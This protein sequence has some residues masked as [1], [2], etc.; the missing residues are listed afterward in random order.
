[1]GVAEITE[2]V[3]DEG[4]PQGGDQEAAEDIRTDSPTINKVNL[5]LFFIVAASK[6]WNVKKC[7]V[8]SMFLQGTPLD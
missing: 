6:G 5:R 1:M 4:T 8:K 7:D 2:V 3:G